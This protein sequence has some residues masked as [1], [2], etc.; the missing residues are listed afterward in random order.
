MPTA[1]FNTHGGPCLLVLYQGQRPCHSVPTKTMQD[2][3]VQI[4][5]FSEGSY[6]CHKSLIIIKVFFS[7]WKKPWELSGF[8]M[9]HY[10][11]SSLLLDHC[12]CNFGIQLHSILTVLQR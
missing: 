4:E 1:A 12:N 9:T 3:A 2:P 11:D 5:D 6:S 8:I 10:N 7:F